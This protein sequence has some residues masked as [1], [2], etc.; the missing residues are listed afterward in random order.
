MLR[1]K[2]IVTGN[3]VRPL[4]F[5]GDGAAAA[6]WAGFARADN[7]LPTIYVTGGSQGARIINEQFLMHLEIFALLVRGERGLGSGLRVVAEDRQLLQHKPHLVVVIDELDD[8][9]QGAAAIAAIVIEELDHA[10]IAVRVASDVG[11]G[12][13]ENGIGVVADDLL[14]VSPPA[15]PPGACRAR[16]SS[17]PGSR[18]SW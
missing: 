13:A 12:R 1:G 10:H 14:S 7:R 9:G 5:G 8:V 3:P 17:R 16:S 11:E 4:I 18:G 6:H 2:A 15:R